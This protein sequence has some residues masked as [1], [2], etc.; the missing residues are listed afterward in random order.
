MK[1]VIKTSAFIGLVGVPVFIISCAISTS[2]MDGITKAIN[3][4]RLNNK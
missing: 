4:H 1:D 2:I 3:S